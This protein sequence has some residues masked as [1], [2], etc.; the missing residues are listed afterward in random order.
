MSNFLVNLARR[1]AGLAPL[2]TL[3]PPSPPAMAAELP[4]VPRP[5]TPI[6]PE[7]E[8]ATGP[9]ASS[10]MADWQP[11]VVQAVPG[12]LSSPATASA[13]APVEETVSE[14]PVVR[15]TAS[16]PAPPVE[17]SEPV[18][19]DQLTEWRDQTSAE[20]NAPRYVEITVAEPRIEE[21][22][23]GAGVPR[24]IPAPPPSPIGEITTESETGFSTGFGAETATP[25]ASMSGPPPIRETSK[26]DAPVSGPAP[27]AVPHA[28]PV[29]PPPLPERMG[30][31]RKPPP[32]R[33]TGE[34]VELTRRLPPRRA[35]AL[36]E[37]LPV[38]PPKLSRRLP[39]NPNQ[40]W[41]L[42]LLPS[43]CRR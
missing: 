37:H 21:T 36:S 6:F 5:E 28:S 17:S 10:N 14:R 42:H 23:I 38:E 32:A 39:P 15:T 41:S 33:R 31:P 20:A 35:R 1:G 13:P 7:L 25:L 12:P 16:P 24:Q 11:P 26:A 2:V 19:P 4:L 29:K 27:S 3:Q 22:P 34:P 40:A 9:T 30:E 8:A 43:R 18:S